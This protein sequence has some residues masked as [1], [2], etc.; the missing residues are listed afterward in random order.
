MITRRVPPV[1]AATLV[2]S[3]WVAS[4]AAQSSPE[5]GSTAANQH[6][7][8]VTSVIGFLSLLATQLFALWRENRNRKWDLED[9]AVARKQMQENAER[10]RLEIVETAIKLAQKTNADREHIV[11][12]IS[13]NT[14]L[15]QSVGEKAEAAYA[16]ANN[17]TERLEKLRKDLAEKSTQ[18]DEIEQTGEDTNAKVTDLQAGK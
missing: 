14:A 10:Q 6:T 16:A 1:V 12:E 18:L 13:K 11:K 17:F 3:A 8:W 15:T 4:V 9:R 7:I 2:L 5:T